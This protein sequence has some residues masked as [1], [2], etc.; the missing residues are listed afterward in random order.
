MQRFAGMTGSLL[1]SVAIG[2]KPEET[3]EEQHFAAHR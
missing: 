3:G 1:L 2:R